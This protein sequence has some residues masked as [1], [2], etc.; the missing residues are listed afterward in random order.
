MF[1][2][3]CPHPPSSL[4][5]CV[6]VSLSVFPVSVDAIREL[7]YEARHHAG[8]IYCLAT[9]KLSGDGGHM[10]WSGSNDFTIVCWRWRK[11]AG[12]VKK[13]YAGHKGG[14]RSILGERFVVCLC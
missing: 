10:I 11:S 1:L 14:V 2:L 12:E 7:V 5:L 13:L 6:I 3:A 9:D 8:G 4:S